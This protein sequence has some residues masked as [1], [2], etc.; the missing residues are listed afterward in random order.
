RPHRGEGRGGPLCRFALPRPHLRGLRLADPGGPDRHLPARPGGA[1]HRAGPINK[2]FPLWILISSRRKRPL[3]A[4]ASRA[5]P[6]GYGAATTPP[7]P[8]RSRWTARIF[9]GPP[10]RTRPP[11]RRPPPPRRTE[12]H[13]F[14]PEALLC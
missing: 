14:S 4:Q 8:S 9:S 6:T 1:D 3:P 7:T 10:T 5:S 2:E 11:L 12:E 13:L